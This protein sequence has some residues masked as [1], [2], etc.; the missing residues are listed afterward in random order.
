MRYAVRLRITYDYPAAVTDARHLLRI[1]PRRETDQFVRNVA[2]SIAPRP[3]EQRGETDFF[4]NPVDAIAFFAPQTE[5][6]IDMRADVSVERPAARLSE[7][8]E[9]ERI[10]AETCAVRSLDAGSPLHHLGP[11]PR[12]SGF[13]PLS[14]WVAETFETAKRPA[15]EAVMA[16]ARRIREEFAYRPGSTVVGTSVAE[17]FAE[18]RGVCQDFSHL[19]IAGLRA[20]GMAARYV[21]GFLR[22][23]PPKGQPR[24]EGADAMHAWIEAWLGEDCGWVGFD[25]TNGIAAGDDHIVVAVGRDYEDAQPIAGTFVTSGSQETRHFVDVVPV[26]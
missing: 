7:T 4:G 22:T 10:L 11:S 14:D 3:E 5:L 6:A 24:L 1:R 18:R 13:A 8:P 25:P 12:I 9:I 17:I 15:G 26:A 19:M 16:L 23:D 21:S 2:V 20:R